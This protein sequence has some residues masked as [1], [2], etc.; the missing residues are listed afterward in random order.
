MYIYEILTKTDDEELK[1]CLLDSKGVVCQI[2][3]D[4]QNA[5]TFYNKSLEYKHDP[6]YAFHK[7][8][9]KI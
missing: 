5:I 6:P 7:E 9:R 1:A 8:T 3:G 2:A 4:Y